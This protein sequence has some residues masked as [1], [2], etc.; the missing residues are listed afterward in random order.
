LIKSD[1]SILFIGAC[2]NKAS[3]DEDGSMMMNGSA[4][5]EAAWKGEYYVSLAL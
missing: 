3:V 4:T 2:H 5:R 1:A